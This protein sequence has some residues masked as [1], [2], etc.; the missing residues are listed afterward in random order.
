MRAIVLLFVLLAE[1]VFAQNIP[2]TNNPLSACAAANTNFDVKTIAPDTKLEQ[3]PEPGKALVYVVEDIG[4]ENECLGG[5]I[6]VRVGLDGAWVG[7]NKGNSHFSFSV[8]PGEHHLCSNWQSSLARYAA[9][10]ALANFVAEA[11]RTYYF[12]TRFWCSDKAP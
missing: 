9:H 8:S 11:G 4:E 2:A 1:P 6:T 3:A 7:A 5:R 12:R 10:H